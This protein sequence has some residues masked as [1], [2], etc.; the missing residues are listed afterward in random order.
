[1]SFHRESLLISGWIAKS[2]AL[3]HGFQLEMMGE[4]KDLIVSKCGI[5]TSHCDHQEQHF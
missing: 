1:M 4:E 5:V 2:S 3:R